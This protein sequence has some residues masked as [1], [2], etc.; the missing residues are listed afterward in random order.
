MATSS[1]DSQK[2]EKKHQLLTEA[3]RGEED[4]PPMAARE[5]RYS[6]PIPMMEKESGGV[7]QNMSDGTVLDD[8]ADSSIDTTTKHDILT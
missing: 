3:V 4:H 1:R 2:I 7:Q 8:L 5:E 6:S